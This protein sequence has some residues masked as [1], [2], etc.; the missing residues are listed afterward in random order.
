MMKNS[1]SENTIKIS[2]LRE[3]YCI[4]IADE[5]RSI[6]SAIHGFCCLNIL[7]IRIKTNVIKVR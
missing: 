6:F 7:C 4:Y 1:K 2:Q 3:I 5:K